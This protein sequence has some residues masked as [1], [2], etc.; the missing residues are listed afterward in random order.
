MGFGLWAEKI[1]EKGFEVDIALTDFKQ[2]KI[3]V[4]VKWGDISGVELSRI[5]DKL[6]RFNCKRILPLPNADMLPRT[7][8]KLEVLGC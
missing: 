2:L 1:V 7:P 3:V 5:E 4:K 6:S 8:E